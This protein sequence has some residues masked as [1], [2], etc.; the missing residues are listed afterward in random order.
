MQDLPLSKE[1]VHIRKHANC[2]AGH[3]GIDSVHLVLFDVIQ[4]YCMYANKAFLLKLADHFLCQVPKLH[5]LRVCV[6][7]YVRTHV[8][9]WL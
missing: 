1:N 9:V 2:S 5:N 4:C 8:Y 6:C 7:V 3:N